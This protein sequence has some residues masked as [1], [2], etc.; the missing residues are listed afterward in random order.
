MNCLEMLI[1]LV[2]MISFACIPVVNYQWYKGGRIWHNVVWALL[3]SLQ[4][5]QP[6]SYNN[7]HLD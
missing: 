1:K 6:G 3:F 2:H 4:A 5:A 7:L